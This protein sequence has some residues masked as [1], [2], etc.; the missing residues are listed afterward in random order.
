MGF[1]KEIKIPDSNYLFIDD[2]EK[3][4]ILKNISKINI[5]VGENNSGKSRFMRT[6]IKDNNFEF[7]P[8]EDLEKLNIF[9][10]SLKE[11]I[12]TFLSTHD[13]ANTN[14]EQYLR[15]KINV[16]EE[17][18]FIKLDEHPLEPLQRLLSYLR[19]LDI[20]SYSNDPESLEIVQKIYD[21]LEKF[22]IDPEGE[23]H[24]I[25]SHSK[26]D[27]SKLGKKVLELLEETMKEFNF[28]IDEFNLNYSCQKLYIPILRGLRPLLPDRDFDDL[29]VKRTRDDHFNENSIDGWEENSN[30]IFFTGLNA[31][32]TVNLYSRSTNQTN[33]KLIKDFQ[34]YLQNNFFDGDPIEITASLKEN[35]QQD[36]LSVKI[37]KEQ[38]QPIHELG[39][40]IQSI[41]ILTLQLFLH[42]NKNLLIFIE[43]PEQYLHP[44]LQ[45]KIINTFLKEEGFENFQFFFTTHSNHFLDITL[46]F[47]DISIF[48]VKKELDNSTDDEKIP[49][50]IVKNL[51]E[52][53]QSALDLLG[54]RNSS[55]FLTNCTIWV[56][57]ITDRFYLRHFLKLYKKEF[58]NDKNW[59]NLQEDIHYSFVE[60]SGN[61][62]THWS[63]LDSKEKPIN[64]KK[65][66]G[67]LF[68]LS[69]QDKGKEQ[70]LE[71][72]KETLSE[73]RFHALECREIENLVSKEVL[74]KI[75]KEYEKK[76][77]NEKVD[78]IDE[79]FEYEDYKNEYL[80]EFIHSK[81]ITDETKIQR[82]C[83]YKEK[84]YKAESG[85]IKNKKDF[86]EKAKKYMVN[87][88]DLT[89]EAQA[90]TTKI[91]RFIKKHN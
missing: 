33:K 85:T 59:L 50:F 35:G 19:S 46:D 90:L 67:R 63:F 17:I 88:N 65:L 14:Y 24:F 84:C 21:S 11:K 69:D 68:L 71:Q 82:R 38:E 61:N 15:E 5:I 42:K 20:N 81:I 54:V 8:D 70:R 39:D 2:K 47:D 53:D 44:G 6:I 31:Y 57:G 22:R 4:D 36:V 7:V 86:L 28:S 25:S 10:N 83:K 1:I 77:V 27:A 55:V 62:I 40:G 23:K 45:R 75:L 13:L 29:Y 51:S 58:N 52:G 73:E 76:D 49:S 64:V 41:I 12:K 32:N 37:G 79:S 48:S 9:I 78:Y 72:L 43:E 66:C 80:G 26:E 56:E 3:I 89:P 91:N 18:N 87:W 16:V 74:L 30:V 34:N 60:Y